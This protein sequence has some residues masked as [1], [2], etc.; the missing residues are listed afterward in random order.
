[1][2]AK[3]RFGPSPPRAVSDWP[4]M[5]NARSSGIRRSPG[6]GGELRFPGRLDVH[7]IGVPGRPAGRLEL[8][9]DQLQR[10]GRDLRLAQQVQRGPGRSSEVGVAE[11]RRGQWCRVSHAAGHRRHRSQS[12]PPARTDQQAQRRRSAQRPDH[13]HHWYTSDPGPAKPAAAAYCRPRRRCFLV[14]VVSMAFLFL[15][16]ARAPGSAGP[17]RMVI[18]RGASACP[19][20]DRFSP[21]AR[22]AP[23]PRKNPEHRP[24]IWRVPGQFR[25][26][27][28][29]FLAGWRECYHA[30][31]GWRRAAARAP[32]CSLN[33]R[34]CLNRS[35]GDG[36]F[37]RGCCGRGGLRGRAGSRRL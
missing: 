17:G 30:P 28:R 19:V 6:A 26:Y 4:W 29:L 32:A 8:T 24:G 25:V 33:V 5:T 37:R 9:A 23:G 22:D 12:Q 3:P 16:R 31:Q 20:C 11:Q 15:A 2:P 7:L 27:F 36:G 18:W 34:I 10:R 13:S 21:S 14:V 1:M 35:H